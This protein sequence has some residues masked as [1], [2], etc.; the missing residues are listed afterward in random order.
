MAKYGHLRKEQQEGMTAYSE[1]MKAIAPPCPAR[2]LARA[3]VKPSGVSDA[4]WR[5]ELRRRR[6]SDY[7]SQFAPDPDVQQ[8]TPCFLQ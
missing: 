8:V 3:K 7:F 2:D 1:A 6:N 4:R 5:I